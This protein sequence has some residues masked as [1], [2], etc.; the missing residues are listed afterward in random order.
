MSPETIPDKHIR[1]EVCLSTMRRALE[2]KLAGYPTSSD[3][4]AKL[5]SS[6]AVLGRSRMALFVRYGEKILLQEAINLASEKINEL[7]ASQG[8]DTQPSAKRLRRK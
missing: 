2:L 3:D 5:L 7:I 8:G 6:N 1:D 4:D